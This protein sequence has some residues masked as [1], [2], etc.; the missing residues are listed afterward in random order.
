VL[1]AVTR[2]SIYEVLTSCQTS[3]RA[4][5]L[6]ALLITCL[7]ARENVSRPFTFACGSRLPILH[8]YK[9]TSFQVVLY[10]FTLEPYDHAYPQ[11]ITV[12]E[13]MLWYKFCCQK[14]FKGGT[15]QR[16]WASSNVH[17][18]EASRTSA[19]RSLIPS[20]PTLTRQPGAVQYQPQDTTHTAPRVLSV[21]FRCH[22]R[23]TRGSKMNSISIGPRHDGVACVYVIGC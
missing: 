7:G 3:H 14:R 12:R 19:Y 1:R 10:L 22:E 15:T 4:V 18:R 16:E 11:H 5:A 8:M 6:L 23:A 13:F 21:R 9:A 17:N 2:D 20:F